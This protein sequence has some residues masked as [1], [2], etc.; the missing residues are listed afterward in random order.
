MVVQFG[1]GLARGGQ[2]LHGSPKFSENIVILRLER[3][4]LNKIVLFA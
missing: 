3:R 4:F 2:T 1:I